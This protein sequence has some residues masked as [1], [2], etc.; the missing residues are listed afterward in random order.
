MTNRVLSLA[1]ALLT[2]VA[3][4]AQWSEPELPSDVAAEL[5]SGHQYQVMNTAVNGLFLGG[6]Q[7]FFDWATTTK[8]IER[9]DASTPVTYT[10]TEDENSDWT[11]LDYNTGLYTTVTGNGTCE[12]GEMHMDYATSTLYKIELSG[13]L[14]YHISVSP[15][16]ATWGSTFT[17][18][19]GVI[20][21]DEDYPNAVYASL[22][23]SDENG[24]EW[25][26]VDYTSYC[27]HMEL[28]NAL[29]N[30]LDQLDLNDEAVQSASEVYNNASST[31]EELRVAAEAVTKARSDALLGS[32][33]QDNPVDVTS[34]IENND[35]SAGNVS[36][37]TCTFESGVS[38]TNIGYQNGGPYSNSS[39]TYINHNGETVNPNCT[40][41]IEAWT[42]NQYGDT[43][44][45]SSI[46]D[47]ELC[48]TIE[49]LAAGNYKLAADVIAVQQYETVSEQYGV[50]LFATS[51]DYDLYTNISTGNGIPEHIE[52][53][54]AADGG[55]VTLGLRTRGTNCNWIGADNFELTYYGNETSAYNF[56]LQSTI[57]NY[58]A[59]YT[60]MD[61]VHANADIKAAFEEAMANGQALIGSSASDEEFEAAIDAITTSADALA[62]SV[63]EYESA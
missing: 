5:V 48:Q 60:D 51:G 22:E 54:F 35:F 33:S 1:A 37:W 63:S 21:E 7:T 46:G 45:G 13:T 27:A 62:V 4:F 24:C 58:Q 34:L 38:A 32:A 50:Q 43:S 39:Y 18:Y 44:V 3:A 52:L 11:F 6:G 61:A 41:F 56:V 15:N 59:L 2:G 55:D 17:G 28:Y 26:F 14:T 20:K 9:S 12:Y 29:V 25:Q 23:L 47:A 8:M 19:W 57:S 40:N 16:D 10:L 36:G 31:P 53:Y 42:A 49:G 30:A